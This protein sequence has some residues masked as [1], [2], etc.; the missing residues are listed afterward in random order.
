MSTTA[1]NRHSN[2]TKI[3]IESL[4]TRRLL[5]VFGTPWPEARSLTISFP[6]DNTAIGVHSNNLRQ[7]LDAVTQRENWQEVALRAFQ[8]WSVYADINVGLRNDYGNEFGASGLTVADPRFGDFR[9]GAFPQVGVLANAVPFQTVAGTFSGDILLNSN[10]TF[11]YYD[12]SGGVAPDPSS[13][14][15]GQR[16]L[17]SLIL[18]ES[19]NALGLDD[20]TLDWSVMFRQYNVPKGMLSQEDIDGIQALYGARTDPYEQFSNDQLQAAT[21]IPTPVGFL[22]DTDRITVNGSLINSLDVDHYEI[23]PLAGQD[24]V[25]IRLKASG[26]S[27]VKTRLEV[28][29]AAGVVIGSSL[30]ES[31]FN[32]D[33]EIQLSGLQNQG[34]LYVRVTALDQDVFSVGDYQLEVDYRTA[35]TQ[36]TDPKP[37]GFDSGAGSLYTN[38]ALTDAELGINDTPANATA[39]NIAPG[40]LAQDRYEIQSA[41]SSPSDIDY[42]RM[43]A[44]AT[45]SG[46][47][48]V[49]VSGVGLAQPDLRLRIVDAAGQPVGASGYLSSDGMWTLEVAQPTAGQD[50]YLRISVDPNSAVSVGNYVASAEFV[51]PNTQ[52]NELAAGQLSSTIDDFIRWTAGKSKLYRFDLNALGVSDDEGVQLTIYDAQTQEVRMVATTRSGVTR[53]AFAWLPEGDYILRFTALSQINAPV[54]DVNYT[55]T[56][57]GISDDQDPDDVDPTDNPTYDPY[58]TYYYYYDPPI[59]VAATQG[60]DPWYGYYYYP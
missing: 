37:G 49:N 59:G 35:A 54:S 45:V 10:E 3:Q 13:Q 41:V 43:T 25:T 2:I 9:I 24:T 46:R 48:L 27:L 28:L 38:F 60:D 47:L 6:A 15:P 5:A 31:V 57:D 55:L 33:N 40:S 30:S 26:I 12:W 56:T 22:P 42:W 29:D 52:L 21:L 17:L 58:A 51:T 44:P 32:N 53:T 18:H 23:T 14:I 19:G 1:R 7:T 20:N 16:D 36:A 8:T 50:Y 11:S 34:V 4:E 39:A